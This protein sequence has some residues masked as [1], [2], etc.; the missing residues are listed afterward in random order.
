MVLIIAEKPSLARN[1]VAGI[2]KM[3]KKD[4]YF[5]NSDYIVSWAFGHLFSLVDVETYTGTT[6]TGWTLDT[7]PCFPEKFKFELKRGNDKKVDSGVKKQFSVIEKLINRPDVDTV[8][9]AGD[10]DREGEIIVRLC[11]QNSLKSPKE[12]KRL[13]LP[14][15]TPETVRKAL[16]EMKD[17]SEYNSLAEEGFARTYIDWLY[18]VNLTRYATIRSGQLLRVGRVIVPIVRAIYDRDIEI[19]NFKPEIYYAIQSSAKTHGQKIDLVSKHKFAKDEK[20][21]AEE[22]ATLYNNTGAVVSAVENKKDTI[23]PGKLYSLSTLQNVLGKKYKMSM[24]DSL[25][26]I[27]KLYEEGY[28]TYPRT[29]SEYLAT[30]EKDKMRSIIANVSKLGYP[31]RFKDSKSI[32]DDSKIESHSA[33]TPTYK[34]PDV[35]KLDEK[36][37]Q[38]YST[39]FRRFVAVFCAEECIASKSEIRIKVGELE[40]FS[41]KGTVILEPGW[42]KYDDY[43]GKDK[44]LPK[45]TVGESVNIDFQPTEKE[46]TPPKHYTIETLNKYLKNPFKDDKAKARELEEAGEVDDADDY[47]AIF[48]GLELGTE[49]T[50]TGII[51]NARKSGYI[52]LKKDVYTILGGGEFLIESLGRLG[53]AMDKY[54]TSEMGKA[55]KKVFHGEMSAEESVKLAEREILEIFKNGGTA[56]AA[57][58]VPT[59]SLGEIVGPCPLCGKNVIRGRQGYGCMGYKEGCDFRIGLT[60]CK[61]TVPINQIRALLAT[62]TTAK[63]RGFISKTGKSFDG[64]LIIKDGKVVFDFS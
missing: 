42:T 43:S 30:A 17:E 56:V 38:V 40:E 13:W 62:G 61:K 25:K 50:R 45:L 10:A 22:L 26:I 5:I 39:V 55:L 15:Q 52:N 1:I 35:N 33:L 36:E 32:F 19:R 48:E 20:N 6:G 11:I 59:G 51:D 49:A 12:Q 58:P 3:D 21:K 46:T 63:L 64:K 14:D 44:V 18:G 23:F 2:G 4:G 16:A 27:Q 28:L 47:R 54:K 53:I 8:V 41:L 34:I 60:I 31:V 24:A 57:A 37:K 7:L 29:N 9:N